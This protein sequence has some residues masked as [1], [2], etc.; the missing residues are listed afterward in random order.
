MSQSHLN[1]PHPTILCTPAGNQATPNIEMLPSHLPQLLEH[2]LPHLRDPPFCIIL[3][4]IR[5][6]VPHISYSALHKFPP[7]NCLTRRRVD[8][9]DVGLAVW[10]ANFAPGK[11]AAL[12]GIG[13]A[14]GGFK[15][16]C[17]AETERVGRI[18]TGVARHVQR[19]DSIEDFG[20]GLDATRV[21]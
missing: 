17:R 3:F 19:V 15:A 20:E 10:D 9:S 16:I 6:F 4:L 11:G 21:A 1:P 7:W 2:L 13:E 18:A 14:H 5:T 8:E 12:R